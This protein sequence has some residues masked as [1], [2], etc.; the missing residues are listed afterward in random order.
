MRTTTLEPS[1]VTWNLSKL[2]DFPSF[3]SERTARASWPGFPRTRGDRPQA[4]D[5]LTIPKR[6]WELYLKKSVGSDRKIS[7]T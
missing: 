2:Q 1:A 5:L 7:R 4:N 6:I 3:L